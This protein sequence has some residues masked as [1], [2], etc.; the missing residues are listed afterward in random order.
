M[1]KQT[2]EASTTG[3]TSDV[4]Q[5]ETP[6]C[7]GDFALN[8]DMP[9]FP[10]KEHE[11]PFQPKERVACEETP[12]DGNEGE[13]AKWE[14]YNRRKALRMVQRKKRIA[15]VE[16]AE[17]AST[18][19]DSGQGSYESGTK[20]HQKVPFL[21]DFYYAST[22]ARLSAARSLA[23]DICV[24]PQLFS[25]SS[26][27]STSDGGSR[28]GSKP[29]QDAWPEDT[30]AHRSWRTAP[31][32]PDE[33]QS[34]PGSMNII[35]VAPVQRLGLSMGYIKEPIAEAT[36]PVLACT[37]PEA[38]AECIEVPGRSCVASPPPGPAPR[39]TPRFTQDGKQKVPD[40][41]FRKQKSTINFSSAPLPASLLTELL[42]LSAAA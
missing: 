33:F 41:R 36:I 22:Q 13:G 28:H 21:R 24:P 27:E 20:A 17:G 40:R 31:D 7:Y 19:R 30:Q 38:P 4:V 8:S 39:G 18:W 16:R 12:A 29:Y 23:I 25:Q 11:R 34:L 2:P 1:C 15:Q 32:V 3:V 6:A 42:E 10:D 37:E 5:Q 14:A 9:C 26:S 35:C